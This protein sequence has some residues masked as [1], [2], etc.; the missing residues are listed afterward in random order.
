M[1]N[2]IGVAIQNLK[3]IEDLSLTLKE[4]EK[5][6]ENTLET[7]VSALDFREHETQ[8]HSK[9]VAMFAVKLAEVM[10][11]AE[12]ERKYIYWGGLLHDIG[13]IGVSDNILLK[14][15][16]LTK[17]EWVEMKKHPEIGYKILGEVDFLGP[18]KDIVLYHHERWDGKGYPYGLKNEEIPLYAR[19]FS[20]ADALDAITSERPYRR[21]RTFREAK[22]EIKRNSGTQFDPEVVK[23]FLSLPLSIWKKIR[24]E[25]QREISNA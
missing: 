16:P 12:E 6:Y 18:A 17:S 5:S 2:Q 1:A 20:V 7:L 13:K 14:P 3:L 15:G 21:A 24:R 10:G 4:L 25:C 19:I 8:F 11:L 22:K 23:V 9:R